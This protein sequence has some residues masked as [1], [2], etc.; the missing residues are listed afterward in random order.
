M[1]TQNKAPAIT[2]QPTTLHLKELPAENTLAFLQGKVAG[3]IETIR[4]IDG[5]TMIVNENGAY[6]S[7]PV[8]DESSELAGF[9]IVGDTVV[10]DFGL[11][12]P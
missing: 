12:L 6:L 8:N 7:L 3:Y 1:T 10:L 4:T 5:R 2:D 11:D 9:K